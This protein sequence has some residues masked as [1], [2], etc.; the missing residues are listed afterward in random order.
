[1]ISRRL[2]QERRGCGDTM[3]RDEDNRLLGKHSVH[4]QMLKQE[5][6]SGM[7]KIFNAIDAWF[8]HRG[9]MENWEWEAIKIKLDKGKKRVNIEIDNSK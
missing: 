3:P 1:M 2:L 8:K 7:E 6:N 5:H 9:S 4:S